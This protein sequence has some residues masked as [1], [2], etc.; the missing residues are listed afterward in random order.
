MYFYF[1]CKY[2]LL[3]FFFFSSRRRHTRCLSDWS[4]DVCS[5][6]LRRGR[7]RRMREEGVGHPDGALRVAGRLEVAAQVD[8]PAAAAG[9]ALDDVAHDPLGVERVEGPSELLEPRPPHRRVGEVR[10]ARGPVPD[11]AAVAALGL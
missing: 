5:S 9:P 8:R 10:M 11:Q 1:H 6:D 3:L 2:Y 7:G 4:S